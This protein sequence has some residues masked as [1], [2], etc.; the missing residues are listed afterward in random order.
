M[1]RKSLGVTDQHS[2]VQLYVEGPNDKV[3][4]FYKVEDHGL[5]LGV[6]AGIE[7]HSTLAYLGGH[8][9]A[10]IMECERV[11]TELA[12]KR[13]ERPSCTLIFPRVTPGT[14][15]QF[16]MLMQLA[17]AVMGRYFKVNPFD[18]PGVEE[19]K[20]A[21]LALLGRP[22]YEQQRAAIVAGLEKDLG[23]RV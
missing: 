18:Q 3:F 16:F 21:A 8:P 19:G 22:G 4:T 1:G 14:V 9:L 7:E 11:G 17:I 15:G 20:V 13:A 2:Q 5:S 10:E 6:P 12:L 23:L